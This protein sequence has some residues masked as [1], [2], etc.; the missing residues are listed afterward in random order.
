[1]RANEESALLIKRRVV[2]QAYSRCKEEPVIL[3]EGPRSVGKSTAIR[4]LAAEFKSRVVD[5]DDSLMR[6][7]ASRDP[8][9]YTQ[10][11]MP[12]VPVLI[13]EYQRVPAILDSIKANVNDSSRPGQFVIAGSTRHDALAGSVQ[14]LTGRIHRMRIY[15]FAQSELSGTHPDSISEIFN[16]AEAFM[17]AKKS[18][19]ARE[20]REGY[21]NR[22]IKGGFPLAINRSSQA[23]NR[24][25]DDY[26]RQ[27]IERDIPDIARIR[28]KQGLS[29]LLRKLAAQTAQILTIE[30]LSTATAIDIST[31]RD[32]IQLL[33]DVFMIYDIPAWGRTLKS[34]VAAK[35]KIHILDS[36]LAS[37]L[38]GMTP[39]KLGAKEP[40]ALTE[41]GHLLETFVIAEILKEISWLDDTVL[42]G[43]WHTHDNDEV[44]LVIELLDGSVYGFEIKSSG[45]A[46]GDTF[47]GLIALKKFAGDSFKAGFVLYTGKSAFQFEDKL[48]ALPIAKFWE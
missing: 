42:T 27:T 16:D 11:D 3:L 32:Y 29:V 2:K 4:A 21:I 19:P 26:I 28:N 43:H 39:E 12:D 13:D 6:E 17:H 20:T 37:R 44:D 41:F 40:A 14:A 8:D 38:L 9:L 24:W 33:Q 34:R 22:I 30:K 5:L 36:G 45:R 18:K 25:F 10:P 35:P 23:R 31:A 47:K 7:D 1:M 15:P 48:F 46:P